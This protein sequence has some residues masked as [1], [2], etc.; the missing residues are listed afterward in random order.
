MI[1]QRVLSKRR[2]IDTYSGQKV[3]WKLLMQKYGACGDWGY[4]FSIG[5]DVV[6]CGPCHVFPFPLRIVVIRGPTAF[7]KRKFLLPAKLR[8][9]VPRLFDDFHKK[10]GIWHRARR[11]FITLLSRNCCW[12][13]YTMKPHSFGSWCMRMG[14]AAIMMSVYPDCFRSSFRSIMKSTTVQSAIKVA[15]GAALVASEMF[16][17]CTRTC[18][19]KITTSAP[20]PSTAPNESESPNVPKNPIRPQ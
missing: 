15:S 1:T 6:S 5:A 2:K 16:N 18:L 3:G 9:S 10:K 20:S 17:I 19:Q 7:K 13:V 4:W 11:Q 14:C 12:A 8:E